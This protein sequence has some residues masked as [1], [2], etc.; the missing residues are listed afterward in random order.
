MN[1]NPATLHRSAHSH[2]WTSHSKSLLSWNLPPSS[3]IYRVS[4]HCH[5]TPARAI[6]S[7]D[8]DN[9]EGSCA[10]C[11]HPRPSPTSCE[12]FASSPLLTVSLYIYSRRR[13]PY[14]HCVRHQ[15]CTRTPFPLALS[16][17][18]TSKAQK[19]QHNIPLLGDVAFAA[20]C[21]AG[22]QFLQLR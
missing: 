5:R 20:A 7:S 11:A 18:S 19:R 12:S 21:A 17:N 14:E 6:V 3:S 4:A 13:D 22:Q 2:V 8:F 1:C 15:A 16:S 10:A 9:S